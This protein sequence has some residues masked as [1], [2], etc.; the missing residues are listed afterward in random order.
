MTPATNPT[1]AAEDAAVMDI[2]TTE[3]DRTKERLHTDTLPPGEPAV[4]GPREDV[5]RDDSQMRE[6]SSEPIL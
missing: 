5:D 4:P 2:Q 6:A 3:Q 1:E